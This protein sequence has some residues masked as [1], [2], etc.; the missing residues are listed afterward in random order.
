MAVKWMNYWYLEA[1]GKRR[2]LW[3]YRDLWLALLYLLR[4]PKPSSTRRGDA[5]PGARVS[6]NESEVREGSLV[7]TRSRGVRS[8]R[9]PQRTGKPNLI[10]SGKYAGNTEIEVAPGRAGIMRESQ[11]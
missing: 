11:E 1:K 9:Q 4:E 3:S 10:A 2:V 8:A 7:S 5:A 6:L